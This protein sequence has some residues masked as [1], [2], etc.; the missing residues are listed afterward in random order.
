V[1][2]GLFPNNLIIWL[3]NRLLTKLHSVFT[4]LTELTELTELTPQPPLEKWLK[5]MLLGLSK[6]GRI[7]FRRRSWRRRRRRCRAD[8]RFLRRVR[9]RPI[10]RGRGQGWA[11]WGSSSSRW[12]PPRRGSISR[13]PTCTN[14]LLRSSSGPGHE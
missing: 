6:I 4:R 2:F 11:R 8:N 5:G 14:S 3:E 9:H 12:G 13:P 10:D 1:S 7:K